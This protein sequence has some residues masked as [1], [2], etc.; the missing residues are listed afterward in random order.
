MITEE[1]RRIPGYGTRYEVSNFGEVRSWG[2]I[3][4]GRKLVTKTGRDG[5]PRVRM[6]CSDGK[7]RSRLVHVLVA[8]AF[9]EEES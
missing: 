1:W 5:F 4:K 3:A 7:I 8:N 9:P 6:M 2:P